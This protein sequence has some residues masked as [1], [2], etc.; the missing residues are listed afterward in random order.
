MKY[1]WRT[2][3]TREKWEGF[4][5]VAEEC[6]VDIPKEG[7]KGRYTDFLL[8]YY[9]HLFV[10][11]KPE[12][13]EKLD[14][15]RASVKWWI[16]EREVKEPIP[17]PVL[18]DRPKPQ[19][20]LITKQPRVPRKEAGSGWAKLKVALPS[21]EAVEKRIEEAKRRGA[22]ASYLQ[23]LERLKKQWEAQEKHH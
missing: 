21:V 10:F 1:Q 12:K 8:L 9:E 16:T 22:S 19:P 18:A 13:G 17:V 14:N 15:F 2:K 5:K 4:S 23:T 3:S 7:R 6:W 11:R 20:D